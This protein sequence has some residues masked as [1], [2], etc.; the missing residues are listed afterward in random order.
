METD[1]ENV[2]AE[3]QNEETQ[4]D[5]RVKILEEKRAQFEGKIQ[6][7]I[8]A[9]AEYSIKFGEKDKGF[10]LL[11]D[12]LD[13]SLSAK[14]L[15]DM[16]PDIDLVDKILNDITN[17][18]DSALEFSSISLSNGSFFARRRL[19]QNAEKIIKTFVEWLRKILH[20]SFIFEV[21]PQSNTKIKKRHKKVRSLSG[22]GS[23]ARKLIQERIAQMSGGAGGDAQ[24]E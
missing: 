6:K 1:Q 15:L 8:D 19:R 13:A 23:P 7:L 18:I 14:E 21:F 5:E 3:T 11:V 16:A 4:I 9:T 10:N 12:C 22:N 20:G 17:C 2:I 24:S